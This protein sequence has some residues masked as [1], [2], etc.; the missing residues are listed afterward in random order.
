M[1]LSVKNSQLYFNSYRLSRGKNMNI[2]LKDNEAQL[3][4]VS[5]S[6]SMELLTEIAKSFTFRQVI[7][8]H[9]NPEK[10][11]S[12]D[13]WT[14]QASDGSKEHNRDLKRKRLW[15]TVDKNTWHLEPSEVIYL[16]EDAQDC[17]EKMMTE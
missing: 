7:D 1:V 4:L 5:S 8:L 17:L 10:V 9:Q 15:L 2:I 11:W 12:K 3:D 16:G 14:L 13:N 6:I